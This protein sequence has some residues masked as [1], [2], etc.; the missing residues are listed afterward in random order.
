MNMYFGNIDNFKV[1]LI[2]VW[3]IIKPEAF[4]SEEQ[5]PFTLYSGNYE[6]NIFSKIIETETAQYN[7][8]GVLRMSHQNVWISCGTTHNIFVHFIFWEHF[9]NYKL[10]EELCFCERS[11]NIVHL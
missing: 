8:M 1:P 5:G 9:M 10:R 4:Q 6:E 11:E 3:I 2:T 7:S